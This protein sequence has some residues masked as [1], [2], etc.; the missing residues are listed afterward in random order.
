MAYEDRKQ[1]VISFMNSYLEASGIRF[2]RY[3]AILDSFRKNKL[4]QKGQRSTN[5][6]P[7]SSS[8]REEIVHNSE[9]SDDISQL[10]HLCESL[11]LTDA[12]MELFDQIYE[13][14][15]GSIKLCREVVQD[16]G[17]QPEFIAAMRNLFL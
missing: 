8:A 17:D 5:I 13:N 2:C 12:E 16:S 9:K 15:V 4:F 14:M 6:S 3:D 11:K 1:F 7:S 10:S